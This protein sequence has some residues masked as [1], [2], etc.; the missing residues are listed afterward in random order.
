MVKIIR[1]EPA[2]S[3]GISQRVQSQ[4]IQGS[5]Q[6]AEA[7]RQFGQQVE[8]IGQKYLAETA[9]SMQAATLNNAVTNSTLE[10]NKRAQARFDQRVDEDGNPNFNT[11]SSDINSIGN[12]IRQN[13]LANIR[14]PEVRAQ[15]EA[16][17]SEA[18]ANKQLQANKVMRNQ[19]LDF[20]TASMNENMQTLIQAAAED[21]PNNVEQYVNQISDMLDDG[22]QSGILSFQQASQSRQAA[23]ESI[24]VNALNKGISDSPHA[25]LRSLNATKGSE[26]GIT[27][28]SR[29]K[30]VRV[31]EKEVAAREAAVARAKAE[32]EKVARAAE[33]AQVGELE[34]AMAKGED[35]SGTIEQL[36][37]DAS[38]SHKSYISLQKQQLKVNATI[39]KNIATS[40]S[41]RR[42]NAN[43]APY[44]PSVSQKDVNRDFIE[45]SQM[46]GAE[47]LAQKAKLSGEYNIKIDPFVSEVSF[48]LQRGD[49]ANA[50]D[51]M[52]AYEMMVAS[53]S[54]SLGALSK[55]DVLIASMASRFSL[56]NNIPND[57]AMEMAR[58]TVLQSTEEQRATFGELYKN[59][60]EFK[61]EGVKQLLDDEFQTFFNGYDRI[62]PDV[63]LGVQ[64]LARGNYTATL[65]DVESTQKAT[66]ANMKNFT[67]VSGVGGT[68]TLMTLPPEKVFQLKDSF[69]VKQMNQQ[70]AAEVAP[71]LPQGIS[72]EDVELVT[73]DITKARVTGRVSP[74]ARLNPS[75]AIYVR[76]PET[77]VRTRLEDANGGN[78]RWTPDLKA[79]QAAA[80]EEAIEESDEVDL[81]ELRQRALDKSVI[82][83]DVT[84][85]Q[86]E[87]L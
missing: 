44:D 50:D 6:E 85:G 78:A 35:V 13:A 18:L 41:I 64:Q 61:Q 63:I 43:N 45:Y 83:P 32:A 5:I 28:E 60:D 86:L 25:A 14:D 7:H 71:L 81:R 55:T 10:F 49:L 87:S 9:A 27:E 26:L 21:D 66:I 23:V 40:M 4:G 39:D 70:L 59:V 69:S 80:T 24:R 19:H 73:D 62:D 84:K 72:F 30:L 38:I 22:V 8:A 48:N 3:E 53:D 33:A 58:E 77:G 67:G 16:Q 79:I 52:A 31:A 1:P 20:A 46:M 82:L 65:G 54:P 15:F 11:I 47:T 34:L 51:T 75:W 17:F 74:E 42:S 2:G 68:R 37:L 12:E 29:L 36:W 56:A 76:N 57:R